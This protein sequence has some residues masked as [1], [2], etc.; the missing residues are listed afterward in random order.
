MR[1][2]HD[3]QSLDPVTQEI[4]RTAIPVLPLEPKRTLP[5]RRRRGLFPNGWADVMYACAALFLASLTVIVWI[6]VRRHL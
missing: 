4:A 6:L 5:P 3:T 1:S 2:P